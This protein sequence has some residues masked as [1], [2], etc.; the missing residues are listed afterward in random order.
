MTMD[1]YRDYKARWGVLLTVFSLNIANN[2]LWI[3]YSSVS[4]ISASYYNTSLDA[5]DWLG[6]IGFISGIPICLLSTWI[7]E[8]HGLR[9]KNSRLILHYIFLESYKE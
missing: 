7:V 6:T 8:H 4:S 9:Y 3:S 1:N 2:A 5:I